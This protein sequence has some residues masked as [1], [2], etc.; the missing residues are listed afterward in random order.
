MKDGVFVVFFFI[1]L[2]GCNQPEEESRIDFSGVELFEVIR[3][4]DKR[5]DLSGIVHFDSAIIAVAD[6]PWNKSLYRINPDTTLNRATTEEFFTLSY[7][8][9]SDF[10]AVDYADSIFY[11][12]DERSSGIYAYDLRKAEMRALNLSWPQNI[13]PGSWGNTGCEA[14]AVDKENNRLF[15]GKERDEAALFVCGIGGGGLEPVNM[16][17]FP[18][19]FDVSDM[20]YENHHLYLLNRGS[21]RVMKWDTRTEKIIDYFDYSFVMNANGE[22]LYSSSRYP[23]AEGLGLTSD[24]IWVALDNN[25]DSFNNDNPWIEMRKFAGENPLLICFD[26]PEGF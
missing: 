26:R 2:L 13:N 3:S 1:F 20:K 21:Y 16:D 7:E 12:A 10:E 15:I 8:F 18:D 5:F 9:K 24:H 19:G 23:M 6:K 22:K 4:G 14:I 25:G 17:D 11:I